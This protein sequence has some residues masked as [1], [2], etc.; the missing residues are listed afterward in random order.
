MQYLTAACMDSCRSSR[1]LPL[2]KFVING[3]MAYISCGIGRYLNK[4]C[5]KSRR[6]APCSGL[7]ALYSQGYTPMLCDLIRRCFKNTNSRTQYLYLSQQV[8]KLS[9]IRP[10]PPPQ[11]SQR[12]LVWRL[13][14]QARQALF[15]ARSEG[16]VYQRARLTG[17][18]WQNRQKEGVQPDRA[19]IPCPQKRVQGRLGQIM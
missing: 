10:R 17:Q 3:K 5:D 8:L 11:P 12:S 7:G 6:H 9:T 14:Q 16:M 4:T 13:L 15:G 1:E 18:H 19:V 2:Y